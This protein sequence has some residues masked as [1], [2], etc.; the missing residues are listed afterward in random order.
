MRNQVPHHLT[1]GGTPWCEWTGCKAGLDINLKA[2]GV[3]CG[4]K[5]GASAERGAAALRPFFNR[6][7]VK[8]V[9]GSCPHAMAVTA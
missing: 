1:V 8:V 6:G 3:L 2:G 4:H 5:S 9:Q 7:R